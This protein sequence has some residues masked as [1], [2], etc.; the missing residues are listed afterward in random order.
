MGQMSSPL[1]NL[2]MGIIGI[3]AMGKGLLY[4]SSITEGIDTVAICDIDLVRCTDTLEWLGYDYRLVSNAKELG[5]VIDAG[6]IAVCTDGELVAGCA[7]LDAV[8]EA[9]GSIIP[10]A[11]FAITALEGKKHLIL[12]NSEIDLIFGPYLK[13]LAQLNQVVCTSCDGDQYGAMKHLIDDIRSWGF[14]LVMAGNIKGFLDRSANPSMIIEEA[15]KRNLDY[16]A[17][18]SYTDGTK[19]NIEMA[20]IANAIGMQT[21]ITGMFGPAANHVSDVLNIFDFKHL[22]KRGEPLVDYILGADPGGGVFIVGYCDNEYQRDMLR[23]Y[24]MG[25]GPFYLF[26]RHYHL[27]HIEAMNTVL[28]AVRNGRALMQAD[29]GFR[30]NV[31]SYA[32][33]DLNP[34]DIL[35][36]IGG[37]SCYGLIENQTDNESEAGIPICLAENIVVRRA[38]KKDQKIMWE[39]VIYDEERLDFKL[40]K[41]SCQIGGGTAK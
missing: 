41:L 5:D 2:K 22:W 18:T 15:D 16:R 11:R 7:R 26:Y 20:L 32:K 3:G 33:R 30:T 27:C 21:K 6:Q 34:G 14:E 13:H 24:K 12:M 40:Y 17:C 37:Y 8:I 19:L 36:G 29:H 31:Y 23:Y 25:E 1:Q 28:D 35:D 38:V 4:Q 9:S 39:D 10:A